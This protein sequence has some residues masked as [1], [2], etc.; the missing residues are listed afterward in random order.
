MNIIDKKLECKLIATKLIPDNRG[1]FKVAFNI[2]EFQKLSFKSVCQLNHSMT[3]LAGTVRGLNYQAP[4][5]EQ[6]KVIRCIKGS[7]FSVAVDIRN[8]SQT[9]GKW[10]GF[11]LSENTGYLM[12]VPRG[13]AHGFITLENNT[14][15]EYFTDNI[16]SKEN[17]KSI[18]YDDPDIGIDWTLGGK[19]TILEERL[20]EKNKNAKSLTDL[21]LNDK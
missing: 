6:A 13:Y 4:P 3:E 2:E 21:S 8:D 20:S 10:C 9:F 19:I 18:R 16:F 15:L 5:F 12:F 14:E 11:E 1:W 17:A 7:L